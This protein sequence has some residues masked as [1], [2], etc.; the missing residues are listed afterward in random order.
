MEKQIITEEMNVHAEWYEQAKDVTVETLP[1]FIEKIVNGYIHDYGTICHAMT[2]CSI[3]TLWAI[4]K[5]DKGGI[6]GFQAG[7]IMWEFIRNW[8]YTNNKV[9]LRLIDFDNFLYPQYEDSYQKTISSKTFQLMTSE[10][11]KNLVESKGANERVVRHWESIVNG[12][13][14]FGYT[15]KD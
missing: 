2:A 4:N 11:K 10:A 14:P 13:V 1:A 6:T 8:N 15:I 7:A 5:T 3:A 9:G 12:V